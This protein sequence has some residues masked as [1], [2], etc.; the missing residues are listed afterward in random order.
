MPPRDNPY[1]VWTTTNTTNGYRAQTYII[2]E[3]VD[4][5]RTNLE[6]EVR[7]RVCEELTRQFTIEP[8]TITGTTE[9]AFTTRNALI[10]EELLRTLVGDCAI[11]LPTIIKVKAEPEDVDPDEFEKILNGG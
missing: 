11:P 7:R 3:I 5:W 10:N 4:Q 1:L 9:A 8:E 6:D 2:D